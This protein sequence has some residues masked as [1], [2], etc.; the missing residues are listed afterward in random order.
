MLAYGGGLRS[1]EVLS[2]RVGDIDRERM[3]LHI[4][5]SKGGKDRFTL[6]SNSMLQVL[7]DYWQACHFKDIVFPHERDNSKP[8]SSS[9]LYQVFKRA[10]E[11]VGINKAGG[12]HMLRHA[13]ATHLLEAGADCFAIKE[14]LGHASIKSTLRYLEFIPHRHHDLQSPLEA[15]TL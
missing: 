13:F 11:A 3:T 8:L 12:L 10:K 1:C 6:L 14:L 7:R 15:L 2:L 5:Q 4:R 9:S